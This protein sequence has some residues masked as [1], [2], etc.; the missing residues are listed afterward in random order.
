[1]GLWFV[2]GMDERRLQLICNLACDLS[3]Y[4]L[5]TNA[6]SWVR[7]TH[8]F[9]DFGQKIVSANCPCVIDECNNIVPETGT[10]LAYPVHT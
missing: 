2:S 9:L 10:H 5:F 3:P 8:P 6:G 4:S 1:M 7:V